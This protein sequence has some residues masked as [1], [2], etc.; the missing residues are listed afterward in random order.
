MFHDAYNTESEVKWQGFDENY[1]VKSTNWGVLLYGLV[2]IRIATP[3]AVFVM[4]S[5]EIVALPPSG[6]RV[7]HI[8]SSQH[9]AIAGL[10]GRWWRP[11]ENKE[12]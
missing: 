5:W 4:H 6:N 1:F 9:D 8:L 3:L 10:L 2:F 12:Y 7:R 11:T